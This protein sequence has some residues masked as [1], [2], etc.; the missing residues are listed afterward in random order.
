MPRAELAVSHLPY[1]GVNLVIVSAR[2]DDANV[3]Y[4]LVLDTGANYCTLLP[5]HVAALD[6]TELPIPRSLVGVGPVTDPS[7]RL[8]LAKRVLL[9]SVTGPTVGFEGS[10]RVSGILFGVEERVR[11]I[12]ADGVLG[13]DFLQRFN[14]LDID[15]QTPRVAVVWNS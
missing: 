13:M 12:G 6:L 4:R 11:R 8:Y 10:S 1:Q 14:Q 2:I 7:I 3:H 9:R 15:P 5:E